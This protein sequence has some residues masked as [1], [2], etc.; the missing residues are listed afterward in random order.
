VYEEK[1]M[2]SQDAGRNPRQV[3]GAMVR[4]YRERAGLS[5]AELAR[6][7]CKSAALV[8]A[9]ELGRRVATPQ[10]TGDLEAALGTEGALTQLRD[11]IGDGLGYQPYPLWFQEWALKEAEADALRFFE[12][13]V[14]PGILQTEDYA[15]AVIRTRFGLTSDEIEE[16][17]AARLKRQGTLEHDDAPRL[18]VVLDEWV[19]RRPVGGQQVMAG[20]VSRLAEMATRPRVAIEVVPADVGAHDGTTGAFGIADFDGAPG[21]GYQEGPA[22]GLMI[23]EPRSVALLELIW[24]TIRGDTLSRAASLALL[25]EAAKSWASAT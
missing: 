15:R 21:V 9:I 24:D 3:F 25:E 12:P 5:R 23:E 20:Q 19:L 8:E 22:G 6:Q 4:F 1:P 18:R 7:V 14:V 17:V 10:V 16:Q 13:L 11:E 2:L